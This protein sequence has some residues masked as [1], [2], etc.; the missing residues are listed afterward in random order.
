MVLLCKMAD[1]SADAALVA[2]TFKLNQI[3][4]PLS[5]TYDQGREMS[6]HQELARQKPTSGCISVT[7][8]ALGKRAAVKTSTACLDSSSP[9]A[10]I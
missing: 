6:C 10:L 2:F 7:P 3:A 8:T 1:S 5:L 9:K 4:A